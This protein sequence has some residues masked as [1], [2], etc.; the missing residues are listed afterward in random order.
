MIEYS[1]GGIVPGSVVLIGGDP[2][3][4]KSTLLLQA[5]D[6]LSQNYGDI[7]YVSGEESVSQ[8]KL[9][10]TRL[11]VVSDRLYV[12]C[13]ND[14]EQIEKHIQTLNPKVVIVDS[15]PSGLF[16]EYPV[17]T[18]E[19][20]PDSRVCRTPLDL[21]EEPKCTQYFL[22][23][24]LQRMVPLAGPRILEHM[25]DTV[26]YFEGEQHHIYRVLRAIKN[27]FGSTNEIGIFEMQN[28]GLVDVMNPSELFLSNREEEVSGSIVVSSM[29][30]TRPLLMEV[31]ALVVPTHHGNPRNTA[32]GVDRHRIALLIAVLNKR[33]GI[34]V[35]G[36]DV[37][38]NITGGLRVAEPGIDLGVLMAI[39]SSYRE[40][41][42]DRQTVMIG[43]VGLGGEIRPVA[44]VERRIREAAKLGFTR[45]I[46][47]EYN[48]KGL[49]I[50]EDIKLIGVKD[51]YDG[52]S[53]LL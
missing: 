37:F 49:E 48:R 24:M 15:I 42:I 27:R 47:P 23:V 5:S 11:G 51:V 34:D 1:G 41:P 4:G 13:E 28:R 22:S 40:I 33:V 7:L 35:G 20:D 16:V 32:T 52:L 44:H 17:C 30:G 53:A 12:L 45:A 31:Q 21:C 18:G 2:G 9:R 19:C 3:I 14:L 43:E 25:V 8:T 6:A 50:E 36:A 46:F 38:V 26:L 10:A 29:E 39:A